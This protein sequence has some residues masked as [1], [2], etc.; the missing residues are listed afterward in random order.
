MKILYHHRTASK[1]GQAVHI[2]ELVGALRALG[3]E[4]V[5]VEPPS[6]AATGFGGDSSFVSWVR[7]RLPKAFGEMLELLYN[8][9]IYLRLRRALRKHRPDFLY[10]RYNLYLLA[11]ALLA[12][13][14]KL[15]YLL[16]VNAPLCVERSAHGGLGLRRLARF[17]EA[18]TWR[19]ADHVLP[20]TAVLGRTVE[21]A[22]VPKERI[23][24]IPN[25]V[26]PAR[27]N[28]YPSLQ[29][30]KRRRGLEGT[31]VLGFTGF[32]RDWNRLDRAI[33]YL[34]GPGREQCVLLVVGEGPAVPELTARAKRLGVT[35]RVSFAGV[36][37]REEVRDWVAAFD[38]AILPA[39][40]EYAS[41]LKL[42]EYLALGRAIIAPMQPNITE[43]LQHRVNGL[44][45]RSDTASEFAEAIDELRRSSELR[46]ALGASA[47]ATIDALQL[48]WA[49]NAS[50]V[51]RLASERARTSASGT[52][53]R[54]APR[55]AV[56]GDR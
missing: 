52:A 37:S 26:D 40:T 42:F 35:D 39:A 18:W 31:F 17:I 38:V 4:V 53:S 19:Q 15:P 48:T 54:A 5:I 2:E 36:V 10:E 7:K 34:A 12:R 13:R 56:A 23:T 51:V 30:A 49:S 14:F 29:E 1:D 45:L 11:G 6:A 20:V 22:G 25:G 47:L 3:H 28:D 46:F 21:E 8:L 50:K 9:P 43:V 33:D 55:S 24:V 44:L 16:E 32:V 27:F 41:P